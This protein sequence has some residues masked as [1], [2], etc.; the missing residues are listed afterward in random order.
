MHEEIIKRFH[1]IL[2]II[3]CGWKI[4]VEKFEKYALDTARTFVALFPWYHMPTT[5][6]KILIHGGKIIE[7]SL[8]PIGQMSEEAQESCNKSIKNFDVISREKTVVKQQ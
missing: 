7:N 3:S 4:N 1:T 2:Q 6:H 5:V 8:L